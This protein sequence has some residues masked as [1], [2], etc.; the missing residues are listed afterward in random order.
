MLGQSDLTAQAVK[1]ALSADWE[2]AIT[3]NLQLLEQNPND[4]DALNR[5]ARAY[6]EIAEYNLAKKTY[7]QVL[8]LD[9]YNS[10]ATKNLK[11]LKLLS[12]EK[13]VKRIGNKP[14]TTEP[15]VTPNTFLEEPGKTKIVQVV[16]PAEPS[17][18]STLTE[19][20]PVALVP[21]GGR[22]VNVT[23]MDGKYLGVLPDD[24]SRLLQLLI[25]GGNKYKAYVRMVKSNF[26]SVFI[27]EIHR[28]KRFGNQPSFVGSSA[29]QYYSFVREEAVRTEEGESLRSPTDEESDENPP[30][31][32]ILNDEEELE[33]EETRRSR[34]N[35]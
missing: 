33:K 2:Q 15:Y 4:V 8:N 28:S 32:E 35:E 6:T 24:L 23:T 19:G 34:Y 27:R 7:Q 30:S 16:N 21:K 22:R 10:I 17:I 14:N 26:L 13:G 31:G 1:A 20:E 18:L 9:K 11:K 3:L 12:L 5:L 29:S 25:R